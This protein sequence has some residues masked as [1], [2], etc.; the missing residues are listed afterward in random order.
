MLTYRTA[1]IW[2]FKVLSCNVNADL[3]SGIS[4]SVFDELAKASKSPFSLPLLCWLN[5]H[6]HNGDKREKK[7]EEDNR[8]RVTI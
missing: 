6:I 5:E 4:I 7:R 8:I 2:N 3:F 1:N